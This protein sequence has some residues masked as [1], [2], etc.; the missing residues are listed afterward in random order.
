MRPRIVPQ[1][2]FPPSNFLPLLSGIHT[3]N[4]FSPPPC[5][6]LVSF[7]CADNQYASLESRLL[8]TFHTVE[9][10]RYFGNNTI[11]LTC[12]LISF[13]SFVHILFCAINWSWIDL[14]HSL[15]LE[16]GANRN[17]FYRTQVNLGSDLWV[18]MSVPPSETL[19]RLNWC[20]SGWWRYQLNT[21]L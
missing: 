20:D 6:F 12:S 16:S 7:L 15:N 11:L 14:L 1:Y 4:H 21:D 8:S 2:T 10:S 3:L 17:Y 13:I 18:R 19:L 5:N 9:K